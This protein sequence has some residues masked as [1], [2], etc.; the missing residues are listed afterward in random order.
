ML[1]S[2]SR[3]ED[4]APKRVQRTVE[5]LARHLRLLVHFYRKYASLLPEK[6]Q[7]LATISAEAEK[8]FLGRRRRPQPQKA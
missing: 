6:P 5:P 4:I 3:E 1:K 2:F 7:D 8:R